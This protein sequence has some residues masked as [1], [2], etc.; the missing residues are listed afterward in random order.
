MNDTNP[1][2]LKLADRIKVIVAT[3][4]DTRVKDPRL[5]FVTITDARVSG[6]LQHAT[7]FYTVFGSE[8]EREGTAAA[9]QSATGMLRR[10]VGRQ[11]GVR[12]TPTLEFIAD[13]VPENARVIED[14]LTEARGRDAALE[15]AKAGA[16]YAGEAD[17]YRKPREE[18][19]DDADDEGPADRDLGDD[20]PREQA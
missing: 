9:L 6:D 7:V 10:E 12:L 13:A 19:L 17:P 3:M 11:T 18:E 8:E 15:Q 14:L 4:L 2:A 1:R 20:S 16:A 5:G